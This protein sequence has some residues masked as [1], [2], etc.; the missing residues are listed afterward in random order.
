[1]WDV[2]VEREGLYE[3]EA[4]YACPLADV[5]ATVEVDFLGA[6]TTAT[7]DEAYDPP[8]IGAADDRF[9]RE[10]SYTKNFR[11]FSLGTMKLAR[12]RGELLLRATKVPGS[13]AMELSAVTL[14]RT[15]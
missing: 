12:G 9:P 8:L 14:K 3:I 4:F 6:A 15:K 1:M 11:A 5:G 10:E 13:Q 2:E 7:I